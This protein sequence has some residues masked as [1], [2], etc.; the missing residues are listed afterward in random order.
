MELPIT[1][2]KG[3]LA[4]FKAANE[5]AVYFENDFGIL[6]EKKIILH[7]QDVIYG[8]KEIAYMRLFT[9]QRKDNTLSVLSLFA[10]GVVAVFGWFHI[11]ILPMLFAAALIG[12]ALLLKKRQNYF[13]QIVFC[14][15]QQ[16]FIPIKKSQIAE[17]NVFITQFAH[18]RL[19]NP[20][21]D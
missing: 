9:S 19:L 1:Q 15:T 2:Y 3:L 6:K 5:G 4:E 11:Y 14:R 18:Y 10:I 12:T 17:C 16:K 7:E 13:L 21:V 8:I 20:E